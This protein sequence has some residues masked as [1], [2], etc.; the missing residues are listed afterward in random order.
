MNHNQYM[1]IIPSMAEATKPNRI[2][3][4]KVREKFEEQTKKKFDAEAVV[5][6]EAMRV[7]LKEVKIFHEPIVDRECSE[8]EYMQVIVAFAEMLDGAKKGIIVDA[9]YNFMDNYNFGTEHTELTRSAIE[10]AE[11]YTVALGL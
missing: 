5:A 10:L 9:L 2:E 11:R 7:F 8:S 6:V 4:Y 3:I 1:V